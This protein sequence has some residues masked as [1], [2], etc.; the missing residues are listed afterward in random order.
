MTHSMQGTMSPEQGGFMAASLS[1]QERALRAIYG[2]RATAWPKAMAARRVA[3]QG[4][5]P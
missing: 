5:R 4:V 2:G 3:A 1:E